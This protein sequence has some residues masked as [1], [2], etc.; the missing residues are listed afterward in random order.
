MP[1]VRPARAPMSRPAA[2]LTVKPA[3]KPTPKEKAVEAKT[4][5]KGADDALSFADTPLTMMPALAAYTN[6]HKL[7]LSNCGLTKIGWIKEAKATLTWLKV[8]GNDLSG[9]G[10]WDG[11]EELSRLFGALRD[12]APAADGRSAQRQQLQAHERALRH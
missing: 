11:I 6:L 3:G 4:T 5:G 9:E 7:N 2:R 10:A 8:E 1:P 12:S